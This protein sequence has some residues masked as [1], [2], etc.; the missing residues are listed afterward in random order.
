[1]TVKPQIIVLPGLDGDGALRDP[2]KAALS[3]IAPTEVIGYPPQLYRYDDMLAFVRERLPGSA[4]ILIAESYGGP[5]ALRLAAE[6]PEGLTGIIF[7]VTFA[8]SP[9]WVPKWL[10]RLLKRLP[11]PRGALLNLILRLG[12]GRRA[13]R[14]VILDMA[15][16]AERL[17]R[18]TA[19][20][21]LAEV[22]LADLRP[23]LAALDVPMIYVQATHDRSVPARMAQDFAQAGVPIIRTEGTHY[24]LE[25]APE[26]AADALESHIRKMLDQGPIAISCG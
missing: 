8:R 17:P 16:V 10:V 5:L 15:Q 2:L 18:K 1:M 21:R 14:D 24:L 3:R 20:N 13:R 26:R 4:F 9:A 23:E 7:V 22:L 11:G 19:S 6:R 12:G 25:E